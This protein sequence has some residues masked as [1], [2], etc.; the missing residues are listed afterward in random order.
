MMC[1][2]TLRC[3]KYLAIL[4]VLLPIMSYAITKEGLRGLRYCEIIVSQ[5]KFD[6]AVYSTIGL[7]DCPSESWKKITTS[8]VRKETGSYFIHLNGPRHMVIDGVEDTYFIHDTQVLLGGLRMREAG[9][10]R[11]SLSDIF[12][13]ATPYREHRVE[14]ETTWIYQAHRP[15]YELIDPFGHVYVM[16]SYSLQKRPLK[17]TDLAQLGSDL[18]LPAGW[19]FRTGLLKKNARLVAINHHAVVVQDNLLNT[20]QLATRDFLD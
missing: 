5:T 18:H 1:M 19:H 6:F 11:L 9:I 2:P 8:S 7:N 16:Q 4:L 14:R 10:V 20:Y 13:G 15:V 17:E 3:G 12:K